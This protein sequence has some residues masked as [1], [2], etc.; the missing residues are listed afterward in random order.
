MESIFNRNLI[1]LDFDSLITSL[2][3]NDSKNGPSHISGELV[4][5]AP[6]YPQPKKSQPT[7]V[8]DPE[9]GCTWTHARRKSIPTKTIKVAFD[10]VKKK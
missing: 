8:P 5:L 6:T 7:T 9:D 10:E 1:P 2:F 4:D 3:P